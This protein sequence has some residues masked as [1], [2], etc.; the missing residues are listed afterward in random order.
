MTD[1]VVLL[2]ARLQSFDSRSH[3]AYNLPCR[4]GAAPVNALGVPQD[5]DQ[6]A[7]YDLM[8][9]RWTL[10]GSICFT[11]MLG[12]ACSG[13]PASASDPAEDSE[14]IVFAAASLSGPVREIA[15][16]FEGLH[17][18]L[19]VS[20]NFASSQRLRVQIEQGA[21]ADLFASANER[22][23]QELVAA[24]LIPPVDTVVFAHN[25]MVV[26]LPA[27][28]PGQV[29]SLV[30]L[31][32]PGLKLI[33]AGDQVPAGFYARQVL[34]NLSTAAPY[35]PDFKEAV[36]RNLVSNEDNVKQVVA[37]VQLGEADAGF[38]YRSDVTPD[39][40]DQLQQ[41]PIPDP[42]NVLATYMAGIP[43]GTSQEALAHEFMDFLLGA[44]GQRI[45]G[46]WG[47][48][49]IGAPEP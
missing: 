5:I 24:G 42:F 8:L 23:V 17:P 28:N 47:F 15:Q 32:R 49:S 46:R 10:L 35:G 21:R 26:I 45:L 41:I 2:A 6:R 37:K 43:S 14:L 25:Q 39:R 22:Y 3:A 27:D 19:R 9:R 7:V 30:D 40:R 12:I 33:L 38:V 18:G 11:M 13:S 31:A 1:V 36:L 29:Q 4:A 34:E 20:S 16:V 48:E 44:E